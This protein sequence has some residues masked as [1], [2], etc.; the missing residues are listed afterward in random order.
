[1]TAVAAVVMLFGSG[2]SLGAAAAA[3]WHDGAF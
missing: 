3:R 1:M 2:S